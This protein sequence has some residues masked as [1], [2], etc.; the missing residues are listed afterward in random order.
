M[1]SRCRFAFLCSIIPFI[2]T[3]CWDEVEI[4]KQVFIAAVAI[5]LAED[6]DE[7]A[8][9]EVTE[10]LIIPS[11]LGSLTNPGEGKA[12]HNL[13]STGKTIYETAKAISRQESH[14]A[15][16]EHLGLVLISR[17]FAETEGMLKNIFDVFIREQYM[18]R[19]ILVV[20]T[21]GK[22]K[23]VLHIDAEHVS[24]P[25]VYIVDMLENDQTTMTKDPVKLGDIHEKL[26]TNRSYSLPYL[27]VV[28]EKI[29]K[30][31][32]VAVIA[33]KPS[34]MV[35]ALTGD[36]SEDRHFISGKARQSVV[37]IQVEG[38]PA[39]LEINELRSRYVL[40]NENPDALHFRVDIELD[41][42]IKEYVGQLDLY[43]EENMKIFTEALENEVHKRAVRVLEEVKDGMQVDILKFDDFLRIHHNELWEEIKNDWDYG[44]NYF[45]DSDITI[46]VEANIESPGTSLKGNQ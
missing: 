29:L 19:G 23:E 9:V 35:G 8:L 2:L 12:Y 24:L 38:N 25:S 10:H 36:I 46:V 20:I 5:D 14:K 44:A 18:R 28:T 37:T 41:A 3:G 31:D 30:Y 45:A 11:A 40:L 17:E 26:L 39:T 7:E 43:D 16:V 6:S 21:E 34:R 1:E 22:A 15:N 4:D 33:E 27:S 42:L 13:S 32:G